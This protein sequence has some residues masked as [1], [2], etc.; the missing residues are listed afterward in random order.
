VDSEYQNEKS[1]YISQLNLTN[2]RNYSSKKLFF[3]NS[4]VLICGNNGIG[5]TNI[6]EGISFLSPGRGLRTANLQEITNK[7]EK[8]ID[9]NLWTVYGKIENSPEY[10]S[11]GT[12]LQLTQSGTS[13]RVLYI[14]NSEVKDKST[15][16]KI[17]NIIW[18]TP[19][20]DSLFTE[21]PS[22]R[23]KFMD[24][25]VYCL[26]PSHTTR[27]SKYERVVQERMKLLT[28]ETYH[29]KKWVEV[30]EK[31]ISEVG[32]EIAKVRIQTLAHLNKAFQSSI[33]P[34]EDVSIDGYF[35]KLISDGVEENK[36]IETYR[37]KLEQ[38]RTQDTYSK[39]TNIGVHKSD[40][41]VIYKSKNTEAQFC[42]TGEQKSLLISLTLAKA[43]M[44]K[45]LNRPT[46]IL[47]LDE[48]ASHLD[49][50]KRNEL[51]HEISDLNTQ[52]FLTGTDV[53]IFKQL[54]NA[55]FLSLSEINK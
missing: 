29:D 1:A 34:K 16:N 32:T 27:V 5:K 9:A 13:K 35:E 2:F 7:N 45:M 25:I 3:S 44:C 4:P 23:R 37:Q 10:E 54:N 46:P 43:R 50:I 19:Q 41:K 14:N 52:C 38:N 40:L 49:E 8:I 21:A 12:G 30:L 26:D 17:F 33:F 53:E 39:K 55:E 47:L 51:F 42:S 18:L 31:T 22:V 28:E 20:D 11:I 15:L 48:I 24:R 6:L 36:V